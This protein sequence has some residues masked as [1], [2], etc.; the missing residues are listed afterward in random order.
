MLLNLFAKPIFP[1]FLQS[2]INC[3]AFAMIAGLIIVPVVSLISP[4]PDKQ[5]VEDAFACYNKKVL[6]SQK[7]ALD[8]ETD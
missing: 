3:G 8:E 7:T 6:V 4:K 1:V 2:P 5:T